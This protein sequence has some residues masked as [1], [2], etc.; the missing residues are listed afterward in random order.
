MIGIPAMTD[1]Y[2][3]INKHLCKI[4]V[5]FISGDDVLSGYTND[6]DKARIFN[7]REM[8]K[9]LARDK[10]GVGKRYYFYG[11]A[12]ADALEKARKNVLIQ[13]LEFEQLITGEQSE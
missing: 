2:L 8:L 1:Q 6:V 7:R 5:S 9:I 10:N 13:E 3:I 4:R 12:L 11:I